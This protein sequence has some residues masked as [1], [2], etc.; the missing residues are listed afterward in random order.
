MLTQ[1]SAKFE[2]GLTR[3]FAH[4]F[5][6]GHRFLGL[7]GELNV[8]AG[9]VDKDCSRPL[10][11]A[12]AAGLVQSVLAPVDRFNRLG[13]HATALLVHQGHAVGKAKH[14]NGGIRGHAFAEDEADLDLEGVAR[15]DGRCAGQG[16]DE[17]RIDGFREALLDEQFFDGRQ[18]VDGRLEQLH[19][20]ED[21]AWVPR[22]AQVFRDGVGGLLVPRPVAVRALD[23]AAQFDEALLPVHVGARRHDLEE[24]IDGRLGERVHQIAVLGVR[25]GRA[26]HAWTACIGHVDPRAAV[27]EAV[28]A[29][30]TADALEGLRQGTDLLRVQ[31]PRARLERLTLGVDQAGDLAH[32]LDRSARNAREIGLEEDAQVGGLGGL[33]QAIELAQF[34]AVR[35]RLDGADLA[36]QPF[37]DARPVRRL[38]VRIDEGDAG[39]WVDDARHAQVL[40]DALLAALE[41]GLH[42]AA[43]VEAG[44]LLRAVLKHPRNALFLAFDGLVRLGVEAKV[45]LHSRRFAGDF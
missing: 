21:D 22:F 6:V 18:A 41:F 32:F 44:H 36:W 4:L 16:R 29:Q 19:R 35:V 10:W 43:H 1:A 11:D 33:G 38:S 27:V 31:L 42:A 17:A 12:V 25:D 7:G 5:V 3:F 37:G 15:T 14:F 34:D 26:G 13:Q 30:V 23:G 28:G 24:V 40:P 45:H 20:L 8:G 39:V 2:H 9:Q